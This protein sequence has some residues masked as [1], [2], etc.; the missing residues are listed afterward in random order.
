MKS[1]VSITVPT[2]WSAIT[3]EQYLSLQKD[4]ETYKDLD[5]AVVACMFHHLCN[6]NAEYISKLD[7]ETFMSIKNDLM[8]FLN[9]T[10]QPL[11]NIIEIDGIKYGFEPNL[12]KIAYGA[13]LDITKYDTITIDDNWAKIM[14]I[15]YRPVVKHNSVLYEIQ[16]Y[17]GNI[18]DTKFKKV[19]MDI[20]FGALF[21]F[22][23]LLKDLP[24][25]ILKSLKLDSVTEDNIKSILA[26]SGNPIQVS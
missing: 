25:S 14:S 7:T 2:S 15:L 24:S 22:I 11:K 13:Y 3:L 16:P 26:K 4:I 6:F 10:E 20:H 19:T 12:S 1:N 17:D 5:E 8:N 18:D 21:F 9:D 23:N